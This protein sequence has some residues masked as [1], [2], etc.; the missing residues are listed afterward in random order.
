MECWI[1]PAF[2][3]IGKEGSTED[4][5]D[6]VARLWAEANGC[7]PEIAGLVKQAESG[8]PVGV[9]GAM[10]DLSRRF[11][12]WEDGFSRGLY[13]AGAECRDDAQPPE[14]WV[15]W[16]V[17]GFEYMRIRNDGPEAFRHGLELLAAQGL[18]LA[19]AVQEYNDPSAGAAY[20]CYPVRR[21]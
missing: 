21:L 17:P 6:F 11:L 14:G 1:K 4:G 12:P 10:T 16:D 8:A 15:R 5:P 13:L 19:G 9:W 7:F 3:V 2:T 18:P 20:L